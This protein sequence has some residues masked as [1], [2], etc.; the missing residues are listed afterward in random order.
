MKHQKPRPFLVVTPAEVR[1]TFDQI[2]QANRAGQAKLESLRLELESIE[3]DD[4]R[5]PIYLD[6]IKQMKEVSRNFNNKMIDHEH[7]L[8]KIER[9]GKRAA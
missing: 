2:M 4:P 8:R 5:R 3:G 9:K 6:A 1:R 7:T